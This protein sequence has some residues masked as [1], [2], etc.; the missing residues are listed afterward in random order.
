MFLSLFIAFQINFEL[1]IIIVLYLLIQISYC[2]ALKKVP[3]IDIFCIST[4]FLLRSVAGGVSTNLSISPWFLLTV[5]LLALF[6]AL[7][8]RKAELRNSIEAG[9]I[10]RKVLQ[11][12]SLPLLLRLESLV[13]TSSFISYSLWASGPSLNGAK[14]SWMLLTVPFVL[15]G[16]FRYQFISDPE[17][18]KRR[19]KINALRTSENPEEILIRDKGIKLIIFSWLLTTLSIG[20]IYGRS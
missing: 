12:Y 6:L 20:I 2:L 16:I 8:K 5:G 19:K 4:G 14:T 10:T 3:L 11:R 1:G 13:A 18:F 9:F 17:E 7:E 15:L